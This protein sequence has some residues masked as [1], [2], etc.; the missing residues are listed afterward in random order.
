MAFK[1]YE[2]AT[3]WLDEIGA[4]LTPPMRAAQGLDK[5]LVQIPGY[6]LQRTGLINNSL[7]GAAYEADRQRAVIDACNQFKKAGAERLVRGDDRGGE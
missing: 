2:E 7:T 4:E 1:T 6:T 5:V 3:G